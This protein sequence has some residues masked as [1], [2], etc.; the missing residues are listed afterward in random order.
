MKES[1]EDEIERGGKYGFRFR[2]ARYRKELERGRR[3]Q[4]EERGT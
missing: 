1:G 4:Q 3:N 2:T